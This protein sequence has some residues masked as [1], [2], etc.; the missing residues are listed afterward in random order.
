MK[1]T[2]RSKFVSI[3]DRHTDGY[4]FGAEQYSPLMAEFL[5]LKRRVPR[6]LS[7]TYKSHIQHTSGR[8]LYINAATR[9]PSR[10]MKTLYTMCTHDAAKNLS[11]FIV[12]FFFD[13]LEIKICDM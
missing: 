3:H 11:I 5:V 9:F 8:Y 12:F 1:K 2:F 4:N 6:A 10:R 7:H 13:D